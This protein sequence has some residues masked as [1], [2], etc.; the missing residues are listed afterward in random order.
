MKAAILTIGDELLNGQTVDT[1]SAWIGQ[2][3]SAIGV[4]V[5]A[6]MSIPDRMQDIHDGLDTL[7][8]MAE[9][10]IITGGLGPT[11]DDV[12]KQS[13]ASY[14]DDEL[15]FSQ[16]TYDRLAS[17]FKK[18]GR[19]P[20]EAHKQQCRLPSSAQLI[21]NERGTA[22]GMWIRKGDRY[23]LSMPGVPYEMKGIMKGGG[24]DL[25]A[26]LNTDTYID[27]QILKTVGIGESQIA[28]RIQPILKTLP[29]NIGIAYLPGVASVKLRLTASG[30]NENHLKEI[31]AKAADE[32][33]ANLGDYVYG[34]GD[35][36]LQEAV[37]E[38]AVQRGWMIGTAESCTGGHISQLITSISGSSRYFKGSV[39][40]YANDVKTDVLKVS[41][42][43]LE[44]HGAVSEQVVQQMVEGLIDH[45][46]VDVAVAVSGIAGP[47]GGT[48][49]KPVGTI[50]MA[51]GSR[52]EV[53]TKKLMLS[54]NR[55]LNIRYTALLALDMM[56]RFM[57]KTSV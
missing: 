51:V 21:T 9:I 41:T 45:L 20:L 23:L 22:P 33:E 27:Y 35:I 26:D 49:E 39:I 8:R 17:Y 53:K 40:A 12:T 11:E 48:P 52:Q 6:K 32:I 31:N 37:G 24:L 55:E 43:S 30:Q 14:L 16:E 29:D 38:L 50:W 18:R 7:Y 13:I 56:R 19:T 54:K 57:M 34:R 28:E 4:P 36:T 3:L 42:S 1:N 2:E 15:I 5:T 25:I 46:E 44:A 10:V 47:T